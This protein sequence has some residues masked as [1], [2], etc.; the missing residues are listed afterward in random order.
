VIRRLIQGIGAWLYPTEPDRDRAL[1]MTRRILP[2]SLWLALICGPLTFM[3]VLRGG[4][5]PLAPFLATVVV[6]TVMGVWLP[7]GRWPLALIF[8]GDLWIA[9][10][11]AADAALEGGSTAPCLPL[12]VWPIVAA[13]GRQTIRGMVVYIA[14]CAVAVSAA[15]AFAVH[16]P[17]AVGDLRFVGV[18]TMLAGSTVLAVALAR[19][20]R[21]ARHQSLVDPLTGLLNRLALDRRYEEL[22]AQAAVGLGALCVIVG[23]IDHFKAVN[24]THGHH[25]G[26]AVLRAVADVLRANMPAYPLLY[27]A[28]GEEFVAVLPG[29]DRCEGERIAERLRAAVADSGRGIT[30][31][32]GVAASEEDDPDVRAVFKAADQCLLDAKRAGRDRVVTRGGAEP[33]PLARAA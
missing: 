14:F 23:D 29:L 17:E 2:A 30:M 1:E 21:D 28:G 25:R 33:G 10:A 32:F 5:V 12:L 24:D 31:S 11:I 15:C 20:E 3:I 26:D 13:A 7:A 8:A 18:V 19:A 4:L 27:R 16:V 22:K 6:I 9:G